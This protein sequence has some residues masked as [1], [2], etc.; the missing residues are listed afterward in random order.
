MNE[1]SSG[2]GGS[3]TQ[4]SSECSDPL[5]A[6]ASPSSYQR[7]V[8]SP[9][10]SSRYVVQSSDVHNLPLT[11]ENRQ[12]P[13]LSEAQKPR[14]FYPTPTANTQ[15][16]PFFAT[17]SHNRPVATPRPVFGSFSI[18]SN[19]NNLYSENLH[20][21][22]EQTITTISPFA[23]PKRPRAVRQNGPMP[24]A[25]HEKRLNFITNSNA[26]SPEVRGS[27]V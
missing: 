15:Q 19:L 21:H 7:L 8:A 16:R 23:S 10:D 5:Q 13:I 25:A 6:D 17:P 11:F 2:K 12:H 27:F 18:D 24:I 22:P 14:N 3:D 26:T 9:A 1:M 20:Q 4:N